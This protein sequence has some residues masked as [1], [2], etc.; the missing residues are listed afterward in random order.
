MTAFRPFVSVVVPA[1]DA[2]DQ[3]A[4]CVR[5]LLAVDYPRDR[6]EIVIV[7]AGSGDGTRDIVRKLPVRLIET[8]GRNISR[9]RNAGIEASRGEIVAFTDTDCVASAGWLKALVPGFWR[10]DVGAVAGNII[11]FP[12]RTAVER[13]AARRRSHSQTR[14]LAHPRHPF[15]MTPNVAFRRETFD[16]VGLFDPQFPGGGW[17]DADFC[18]RLHRETSLGIS[19]APQAVVFHR[20]RATARDF[21][22]QHFRYGYGLGLVLRKYGDEL[23]DEAEWASA[24][25]AVRALG[26]SCWSL[27]RSIAMPSTRAGQPDAVAFCC[28]DLLREAGQR[29]GYVTAGFALPFGRDRDG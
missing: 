11:P 5:S 9:A 7:D 29:S 19:Y 8:T 25:R 27:A 28:F 14:P 20:Y 6:R 23:R 26:S 21:L 2:A 13:Y 24:R 3:A 12:P 4:D 15:A 10:A 16:R 17:E 18:W 22:V 1:L